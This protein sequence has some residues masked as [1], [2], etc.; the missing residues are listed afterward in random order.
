MQHEQS[1]LFPAELLQYRMK[2]QQK[3]PFLLVVKL[4][5]FTLITEDLPLPP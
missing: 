5:S 1:S 4:A 2:Q 3:Q